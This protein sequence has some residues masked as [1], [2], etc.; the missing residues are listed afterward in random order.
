VRGEWG[1][2]NVDMV[3]TYIRIPGACLPSGILF[4]DTPQG[5]SR[6]QG[7]VGGDLE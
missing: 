7:F 3:K 6:V 5:C 1:I 2:E 4:S